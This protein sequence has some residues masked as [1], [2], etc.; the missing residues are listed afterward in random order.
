MQLYSSNGSDSTPNPVVA[1]LIYIYPYGWHMHHITV[2]VM[3]YHCYVVD[4][5]CR[6]RALTLSL[7]RSFVSDSLIVEHTDY[8]CTVNIFR[9]TVRF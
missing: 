3:Q 5:Q 1:I 7:V 6:A 4:R 9:Y 2:A 8:C